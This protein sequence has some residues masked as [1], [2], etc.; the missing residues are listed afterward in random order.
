MAHLR[1]HLEVEEV[2]VDGAQQ[3]L[4]GGRVRGLG[5]EAGMQDIP[6]LPH[7]L[8]LVGAVGHVRRG[9]HDRTAKRIDDD[10]VLQDLLGFGAGGH[11]VRSGEEF[12]RG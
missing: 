1:A 3:L 4:E 6:A 11:R 12:S 10:G 2:V 8:L 9:V 7:H 5:N